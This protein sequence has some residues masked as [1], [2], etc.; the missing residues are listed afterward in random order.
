[1]RMLFTVVK[2]VL[3]NLGGVTNPV[4]PSLIIL[5]CLSPPAF[6]HWS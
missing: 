6:V 3:K 2:N 5:R 1:M 4:M